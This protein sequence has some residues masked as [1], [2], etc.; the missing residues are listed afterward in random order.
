VQADPRPACH[1]QGLISL[2]SPAIYERTIG[3]T[4]VS[5]IGRA[6]LKADL[7]ML[8]GDGRMPDDHMI[9]FAATYADPGQ[10]EW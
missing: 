5:D 1:G 2:H 3:R 9:P 6:M 8:A 10:S 7:K 4:Q